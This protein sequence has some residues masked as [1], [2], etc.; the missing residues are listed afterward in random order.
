[1]DL[2]LKVKIKFSDTPDKPD[3]QG[4]FIQGVKAC[5]LIC[6]SRDEIEIPAV[7]INNTI[8]MVLHT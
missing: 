7:V 5:V 4:G 1:M 3:G 2:C 8:F 6:G